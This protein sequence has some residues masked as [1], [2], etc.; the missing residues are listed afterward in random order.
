MRANMLDQLWTQIADAGRELVRGRLSGRGRPSAAD[1]CRDLLSTKGEAS[2]A[3]LARELLAVWRGMSDA[4]RLS[5]FSMLANEYDA[6]PE[7]ILAAV[8]AYRE[9]PVAGRGAE[10]ALGLR[11]AAP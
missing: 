6:E 3:A 5:F 2:G 4:E 8:E 11:G 10:P 9:R 7:R 1:L